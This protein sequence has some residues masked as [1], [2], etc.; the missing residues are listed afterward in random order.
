MYKIICKAV[1]DVHVERASFQMLFWRGIAGTSSPVT[2]QPFLSFS[3]SGVSSLVQAAPELSQTLFPLL[4][5]KKFV[6]YLCLDIMVSCY[7]RLHNQVQLITAYNAYFYSQMLLMV[8]L[9]W[10]TTMFECLLATLY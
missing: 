4:V 9:K 8:T 10:S 2:V 1:T 3:C 5:L 7:Y 6:H